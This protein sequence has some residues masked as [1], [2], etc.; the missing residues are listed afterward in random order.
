MN[1]SRRPIQQRE[2]VTT[3]SHF[4][5]V[6]LI[7]FA[8]AA[9]VTVN[10]VFLYSGVSTVYSHLFYI[11]II[12]AAYRYPRWG[13]PFA[14]G[15]GVLY[16]I[17][18]A[19][20]I[21]DPGAL[22][23]AGLRVVLFIVI[24]ATV[25]LLSLT[26]KKEQER[27]QNIFE[28]S[29]AGTFLIRTGSLAFIDVNR[30]FS[31]MLGYPPRVLEGLTLR[32][33]WRD[34]PS[35]EN[36]LDR[37][38]SDAAVSDLETVLIGSDGS[39]YTV[40]LSASVLHGD[41]AVCT[42]VDITDR[43]RVEEELRHSN[44]R[45]TEILESLSDVFFSMNRGFTVT[46]WNRAA[47]RVTGTKREEILGRSLFEVLPGAR[48]SIL[49]D[50]FK[51]ALRDQ[52]SL[53]FELYYRPLGEHFEV[54]IYPRPDG[55]TVYLT[56]ITGRI[57]AQQAI[58]ESEAK[59]RALF[60]NAGI[61]M[62]RLDL[63]G[64]IVEVNRMVSEILGYSAD[65]L[66]GMSFTWYVHPDDVGSDLA[67]FSELVTGRRDRYQVDKRYIRKDGSFLWGR[68]TISLVRAEDGVPLAAVAMVENIT[69]QK[70]A[71]DELNRSF[72]RFRA[73]MDS[74][75]AL[76][77]VADLETREVLFLNRYGMELWGD[78]VG[79]IC[80]KTIRAE[81]TGP[82][83]FCTNS[84]L[85]DSKGN[86]AGVHLWEFQNTV[87]GRWYQCRDSA[88]RWTDGRFVRMEIATD[89]TGLKQAEAALRESEERY[90]TLFDHAADAIF[91]HDLEG[92]FLEVNGA[93]VEH[94]GYSREELLRMS[95]ADI[96]APEFAS[97]VC[98]RIDDLLMQGHAFFETA[99]IRCDGSVVPME[100][101][102]CII[103]YRA[104]PAVLSVARD[105]TVRKAVE[106]KIRIQRD[107]GLQLASVS[108]WGEAMTLCL[109]MAIQVLGVDS[110]MIYRRDEETGSYLLVANVNLS[111]EY[112]R[113]VSPLPPG[114]ECAQ[115][116]ETRKPIY[117]TSQDV[118]RSMLDVT[119]REGICSFALLPIFS[120]NHIVGGCFI[121]SHTLEEVP[122]SVRDDLET[123]VAQM[124]N[125]L[126][127]I[128]AEEEL[129]KS[130]ERFR[131]LAENARD[132]I[133]RIEFVPERRFT[134]VSPAATALTGYSPEEHYADPDLG[135]KLVHPD[136]R[137]L[138][139]ALAEGRLSCDE[140]LVLRWVKKDGSV[141][142]TEQRNVPIYDDVGKLVAM[143]GIARDVTELKQYSEQ[144]ERSLHEK[145]VLLKEV[146]HRVK[147][148]MQVISSLMSL[149]AYAIGDGEMAGIFRE[150]EMRV[151]SMALVHETLYQSDD[152]AH[153]RAADYVQTLVGELVASYAVNAEIDLH[154]EI[155]DMPLELEAA[156][157]C[158]L[159]INELVSNA[160]KYA[161]SG[162]EKGTLGVEMHRAADARISLCV[163]DDGIGLPEGLD[164]FVPRSESLGLELVNILSRQLGGT[165]TC[166]RNAGTSFEITF[167]EQYQRVGRSME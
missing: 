140:P 15:V 87:T 10:A 124:G 111:D 145:D 144:L 27:Y 25:T 149:Q 9:T 126:H 36:F 156:I 117:G 50:R 132:L 153:I 158:G 45:N 42:A 166:E 14:A 68:Q 82:C 142:W 85:L 51:E 64:R 125:A 8:L 84:Q 77:Y 16:L 113:M 71:E 136:D 52:R 28:I 147:N 161:F 59:F 61:G 38:A 96:D 130:E 73:V 35:L 104:N 159:I 20:F 164:P 143:E 134:Y 139:A 74:L 47:E 160:L 122:Q 163:R 75:D 105:I 62:A 128:L 46:S 44:T 127:R 79:Q 7:A 29:E 1:E 57:R 120:R 115:R 78:V 30:R 41:T 165:L 12:L 157:P 137:H 148:N 91:I 92:R 109:K 5:W 121:A 102:S 167:P 138:F 21:P 63:N 99:H 155:D 23:T 98:E 53:S 72:E 95:L 58:R 70:N 152:F 60:S 19:V 32:Q 86:P 33:I 108:S 89:I 76:V 40:L 18:H 43:K 2:G 24:G 141:V 3:L 55:L 118:S 94:L 114:C 131:L 56:V 54:R 146:H 154:V 93:A 83:P 69:K 107:F 119:R 123:L 133:Y 90:R 31:L 67:L 116:F 150:S 11:P 4:F 66:T 101:S 65:E 49:W 162:R 103:Q 26:L 106:E 37:L 13:V 39:E 110:G 22:A 17:L 129:H 88:I 151:K 80:W 48:E 34:A 112:L 6:Y 97:L 100:L 81:Q 135:L